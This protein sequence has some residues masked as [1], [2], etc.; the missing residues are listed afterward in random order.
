M[1]RRINNIPLRRK[2]KVRVTSINF[3]LV[4]YL[5][6]AK[7]HP[8][9]YHRRQHLF[10]F[11]HSNPP[12]QP[13]GTLFVHCPTS[14][15]NQFNSCLIPVQ[16]KLWQNF[17]HFH[18]CYQ[19]IQK[20]RDICWNQFNSCLIPVQDKLRQDFIHFHCCYQVVQKPFLLFCLVSLRI[21]GFCCYPL[22]L[23]KIILLS[24]E[25]AQCLFNSKWPPNSLNFVFPC[26]SKYHGL[27]LS[28]LGWRYFH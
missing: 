23:D 20:R 15:W 26:L 2:F 18:C 3:S 1:F 24:K 27:Q 4:N 7:V 16:D 10:V 14:C 8:K 12:V 5:E 22:P 25:C 9:Y 28:P 17:I 11:C 6:S 13:Y 21:F 19:V